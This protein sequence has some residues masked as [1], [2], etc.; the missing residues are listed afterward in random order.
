VTL[1]AIMLGLSQLDQKQVNDTSEQNT[2]SCYEQKFESISGDE[3][4]SSFRL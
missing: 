2:A 4:H 1:P 3:G